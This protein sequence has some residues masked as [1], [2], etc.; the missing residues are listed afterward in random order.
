MS[1]LT[2]T[3]ILTYPCVCRMTHSI[4]PALAGTPDMIQFLLLAAI[5]A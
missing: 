3:F 2:A 1:L 4:S 5:A